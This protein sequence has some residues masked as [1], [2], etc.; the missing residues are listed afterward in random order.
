MNAVPQ[1]SITRILP[2][3]GGLSAVA[4]RDFNNGV[5]ITAFRKQTTERNI[6]YLKQYQ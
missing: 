3:P 4:S 6:D 5:K 1:F 2:L